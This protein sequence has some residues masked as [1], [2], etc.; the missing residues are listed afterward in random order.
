MILFFLQFLLLFPN[1]TFCRP[2][3]FSLESSSDPLELIFYNN[4]QSVA[5]IISKSNE[6]F[7]ITNNDKIIFSYLN[8]TNSL[9]SDYLLEAQKNLVI[10][11]F[12]NEFSIGMQPQWKLWL[13]ENFDRPVEGWNKNKLSSCGGGGNSFLGDNVSFLNN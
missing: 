7:V 12:E 4:E 5:R 10:N 2:I 8:E 11:S 9:N 1:F 13:S 3:N 6:D